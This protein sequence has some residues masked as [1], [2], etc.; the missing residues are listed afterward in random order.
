M[1]IWLALSNSFLNTIELHGRLCPGRFLAIPGRTPVR[2]Y[3]ALD[4]SAVLQSPE[5]RQSVVLLQHRSIWTRYW[6]LLSLR[7]S[8]GGICLIC[9]LRCWQRDGAW[10]RAGLRMR[11]GCDLASEVRR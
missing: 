3:L 6:A 8:D 5:A 4:G 1:S 10:R 11:P 9:L 7:S 2:M